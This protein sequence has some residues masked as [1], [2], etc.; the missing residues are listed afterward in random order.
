M[1]K[2]LKRIIVMILAATT[3]ITVSACGSSV[4]CELCDATPTKG[5]KVKG[6]NEK[7]YVCSECSSECFWCSDRASKHYMSGLGVIIFVCN[8]CYK[9]IVELNQ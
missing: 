1:K 2:F 9:E 7:H 3:L 5:Y 6:S 8:D 4:P